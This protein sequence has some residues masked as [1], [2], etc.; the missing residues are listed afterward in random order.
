MD[1]RRFLLSGPLDLSAP[2]TSVVEM[3]IA[4][5]QHEFTA[6]S[7]GLADELAQALGVTGFDEQLNYQGGALFTARVTSYDAQVRLDEDRLVAAWRGRRYCFV[8]QLYGASTA[9]LLAVLRTLRI[10]E[11]DDGLVVRP[12]PRAG[13]RYAAPA[14]VIKQVPGLGLLD[15]TPL[16]AERARQLPSWR[17]LRTRAGEL[18]RDTLSDG[19]PYFVL[20]AQ[21]TWVTV[22]PLADTVVDR[23]PDLVDRL[24]VQSAE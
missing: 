13:S 1:G 20:A 22:L 2:F 7:V 8:T 11:H 19:K 21:D 17:G 12:D 14:T 4:G 24:R 5:R 10:A 16:T 18:F 6:G 23:V 9:D 3:T 15:M